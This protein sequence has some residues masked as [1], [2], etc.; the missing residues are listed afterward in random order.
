VTDLNVYHAYGEELERELRLK[1]HPLAI[2]MLEKESDIPEGATRPLRDLGSHLSMCQTFQIARRGGQTV[3]VLLEDNWCFE[4]V[5]CFGREASVKAKELLVGQQVRIAEDPTQD[6]K[7]RY[8]RLLVYLWLEDGTFF[9][10]PHC[11][12]WMQQA[13]VVTPSPDL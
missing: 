6:T 8:G 13:N 5:Q 12:G 3:A 10:L 9:N 7:D 2:K 11:V 4:P 1:T